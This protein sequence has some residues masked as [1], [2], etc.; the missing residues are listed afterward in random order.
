M[1]R[2]FCFEC[3]NTT[4]HPQTLGMLTFYSIIFFFLKF[5][6]SV[7]FTFMAKRKAASNAKNSGGKKAKQEKV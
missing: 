3:P 2:E 1:A 5:R 4:L 7:P 6:F